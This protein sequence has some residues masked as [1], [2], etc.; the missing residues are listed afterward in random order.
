MTKSQSRWRPKFMRELRESAE[1]LGIIGAV[2]QTLERDNVTICVDG[3]I[4][5]LERHE[6]G[7]LFVGDHQNR[8]EFVPLM[9]VLA[10]IGRADMRNIAKFY[11][12][13]QI[14]SA[15]GSAAAENILPVYPRIL[16]SDRKGYNSESINRAFF[17][18]QLLSLEESSIATNKSVREAT[19]FLADGGAVNIYPCGS[20]VQTA[21]HPWR[22]GVGRI[23]QQLPEGVRENT[24]VAPYRLRDF[25]A[26]RF[27]SAVALRGMGLAGRPQDIHFE[28]A[29]LQTADEIIAAVSDGSGTNPSAVTEHLRQS[30]V[31]YFH[32]E[33]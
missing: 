8:W 4:D 30:Y 15:L 2:S 26:A 19:D 18:K 27:V 31:E 7:I 14:S 22:E 5:R 1:T 17:R 10:R 6:G 28:L 21:T 24:L 3:D 20:V 13:R 11:V 12:Q 25:S 29:P 33:S 16:A 9:G 32:P 23:I